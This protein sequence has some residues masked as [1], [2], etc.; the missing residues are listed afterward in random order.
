MKPKVRAR[1][2]SF[3]NEVV[4]KSI[5]A[6]CA[7]RLKIGWLNSISKFTLKPSNGS[8]CAHL[9]PS[10]TRTVSCTRTKRF[11]RALLL[12]AGRLQQEHE[13]AGAAVHDRHFGGADS[14][15]TAL[16][17][18]RPA[19]AD[20]RCS[21]VETRHSPLTSVVP[22][23]VSPTFVGVRPDVHRVRQVGAPEHDARIRRRRAARSSALSYPCAAPRPWRESSF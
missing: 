6:F 15:T 18:P 1:L 20:S 11:G 2:T 12:D 3:R 23:I 10:S 17:I 5:D 9:S 4:E 7:R 22:S 13:R 8:N 16:S 14:S 21:T 19:N